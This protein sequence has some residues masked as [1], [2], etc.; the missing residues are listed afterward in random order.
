ME[1]IGV[2]EPDFKCM[3]SLRKGVQDLKQRTV[4]ALENNCVNAL[5]AM[6]LHILGHVCE[7]LNMS[8]NIGF[9]D[10]SFYENSCIVLKRDYR[11]TAMRRESRVRNTCCAQESIIKG[12]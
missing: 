10:I 7:N 1:D 12:L 9:L 6:K 3:I 2:L 11:R 4:R 5:F 8:G